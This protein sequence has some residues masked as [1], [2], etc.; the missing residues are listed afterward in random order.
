MVIHLGLPTYELT[1]Q[2]EGFCAFDSGPDP[3]GADMSYKSA[4]RALCLLSPSE[5][6]NAVAAQISNNTLHDAH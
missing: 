4:V 5:S 1:T 3:A 2:H 6:K